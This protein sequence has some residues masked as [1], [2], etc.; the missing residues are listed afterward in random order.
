M[1]TAAKYQV[2]NEDYQIST[3]KNR[4]YYS[5]KVTVIVTT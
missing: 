4:C 3:K 2:E 5:D 1:L